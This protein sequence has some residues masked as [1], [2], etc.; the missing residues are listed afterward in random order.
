[1][2]GRGRFR[3]AGVVGDVVM[4]SL[5]GIRASSAL[6]PAFFFPPVLFLLFLFSTSTVQFAPGTKRAAQ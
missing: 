1:M 2:I 3:R 4:M 5:V 6:L